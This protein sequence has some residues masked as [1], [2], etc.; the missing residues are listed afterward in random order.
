MYVFLSSCVL[1]TEFDTEP[2]T[3]DTYVL[4]PITSMTSLVTDFF[5]NR[6]VIAE[7]YNFMRGLFMHWN[8]N[9]YSNFVAWKGKKYQSYYWYTVTHN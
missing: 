9:K 1:L 3:L 8:Y 7:M 4:S 6:P 5:K 2:S